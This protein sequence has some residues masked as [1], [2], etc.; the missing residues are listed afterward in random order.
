MLANED[1]LEMVASY[2]QQAKGTPLSSRNLRKDKKK[3]NNKGARLYFSK[4]DISA[5]SCAKK[6]SKHTGALCEFKFQRL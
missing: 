6:D 2:S 4:S 5:F 3:N 1:M